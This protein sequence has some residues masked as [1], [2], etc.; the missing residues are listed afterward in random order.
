M[1]YKIKNVI[2]EVICEIKEFEE[3]VY[4]RFS[5]FEKIDSIEQENYLKI[6]KD[7]IEI[8][9]NNQKKELNGVVLQTDLYTVINNVLSYIIDDENNIYMHSVVVSN[10]NK[11][12]LI[13]GN[14][15]QGK[16]TLA[17]EFVKNDFKINSTDQTWLRI[18]NNTFE[19]VLGSRFYIEEGKIKYISKSDSVKKVNIDEIIR[20][21]GLCDNGVLT[22]NKPKN[23]FSK[24]K[25]ISDYA[26]WSSNSVLF[27][28]DIELYNIN[29]N[30]KSFLMKL[31][32]IPL[33][34]VRGDKKAVVKNVYERGKNERYNSSGIK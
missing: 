17:N 9:I 30:I 31:E 1:I 11:G 21:V 24:V 32:E 34:N 27:T 18:E 3:L 10:K 28:D 29:E 4:G 6:S 15:G 13:L 26:T 22:I 5:Q 19:Q 33:Y 20:I 8:N 14:F 7:K 12:L 16:T 23:I 25:Q 2:L